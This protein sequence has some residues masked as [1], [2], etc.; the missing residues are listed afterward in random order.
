[1]C[2]AFSSRAFCA[3]GIWLSMAATPAAAINIVLNFDAG[4]SDSPSFD[5]DGSKLTDMMQAAE[6]YW[7]DII[8][9]V[10]TLTIN[11]WWDDLDDASGTLGKHGLVSQADGRET[12]ANVRLDTQTGGVE[13]L[14]FFDTTPSNDSEYAM[15]QT[16][17]RDLTGAQVANWFNGTAP[18]VFEV[19]YRGNATAGA[20]AA[21]QNGY[22]ALS[23]AIHEIGH[24]LG[25]SGDNDSTVAETGDLD[26]DTAANLLDG[27][28]VG[29]V[30]DAADDVAHIEDGVA[31]MCGGCG[32]TGFR[33]RASAA[34]VFAMAATSDWIDID[35]AR[36]DFI[37]G[38]SWNTAGNW[39]GNAVPGAADDAFIR[40]RTATI[41]AALTA[42]G[43]AANFLIA[44]GDTLSTSNN[45]LDI[46]QTTTVDG[47]GAA[48]TTRIFI[49]TSGELE[50]ADLSLVAGNL[51]PRGGVA[52]IQDSATVDAD[53]FIE[54]YGTVLV[55]NNLN[56]NGTIRATANA[57]DLLF[58]TAGAGVWDL[59]GSSG[60]GIVLADLGDMQFSG[61]LNDDF[62]GEMTIG[63]G[64]SI[65]FQSGWELG[66]GGVLNLNGGT[67][68]AS[69]STIS[70]QV[71]VD[72]TAVISSAVTFQS[73]ADVTVNQANDILRLTGATTYNG[74]TYTSSG[75]LEQNGDATV[76]QNTT[77]ATATYDW[78]GTSGTSQTTINA[79]RTLTINSTQIDLTVSDGFDGDVFVNG[80]TLVVN[81][82]AAWRLDGT[83]HLTVGGG[84][85]HVEGSPIT[86]FG[87]VIATGNSSTIFSDVEFR[88]T[89][90]VTVANANDLLSLRGNTTYRG[91]SYT[92]LGTIRQFGPAE[93]A[94]NTTID[95]ALYDW[96]GGTFGAGSTA[97]NPGVTFTINSSVIDQFGGAYDGTITVADTASL[98]VNTAA[99]WAIDPAGSLTLGGSTATVG[100]ADIV[101]RGSIQ[102]VGSFSANVTNLGTVGP[103][104]SAGLIE[105]LGN[106][107][108]TA[109]GR[110]EIELGGT[111]QGSEYDLL[112]ITGT[113]SLNGTLDVS[114]IDLGGGLFM[115]SLG[116]TFEILTA[117]GG[118]LG[119]FA[120][121]LLPALGGFLEWNVIYGTSNVLLAVAPTLL[122]DYNANGVVEAGDY[123]VWRATLGDVGI[124]LPA[125]GD[126]DGMIG[127]GDYDVWRAHFGETTGGGSFAP[128]T[129]PEPS[130]VLLVL[131]GALL[132]PLVGPMRH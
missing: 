119:S 67:L 30:V 22:D 99:P 69:A 132:A 81:T 16:L 27:T 104:N 51:S 34:D 116:N 21:A 29:I 5:P 53:S 48:D 11:Y 88:A 108:Q 85:P 91:G 45:K 117:A 4:M 73:N 92:G 42:N 17:W 105:F 58:S 70:G 50:T 100:G 61:T 103:G 93:I 129:S 97:V 19:G 31:L 101:N 75:V 110:L 35:L 57:F 52:D 39:E 131:L 126:G 95:V 130:A 123:V 20:P 102:G 56:N 96:D 115:P 9:D 2:G 7:Q 23:T 63:S 1:M 106:Y 32:G 107:A 55:A 71:N 54:G 26:Y 64:H 41:D 12:E 122:G 98:Q 72:Q 66:A 49:Y 74:G 10:H 76:A 60:N 114:L 59:D 118:V 113:G 128:R 36:K 44:E 33:R 127:A 112:S 94:A 121:E 124:A 28:S 125:D 46:G 90:G 89:A 77:I 3:L 38:V 83:L 47:T 15:Q 87:D 109:A 18:E 80:G 14:W 8:E 86:I 62:D 65:T 79:A 111:T 43:V 68:A 84:F 6:S 13:R 78:D 40:R 24:A 82:A 25:M 120:T 37:S